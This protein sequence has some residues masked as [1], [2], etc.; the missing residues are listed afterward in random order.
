VPGDGGRGRGGGARLANETRYGLNASVWTGDVER[1]IAARERVESGNVCVNECVISAGRAG[2]AVRRH[3]AERRRHAPRRRRGAAAVLACRRRC[4]SSRGSGRRRDV[5]PLLRKRGRR[6]NR[7][8]ASCSAGERRPARVS[9]AGSVARKR[10]S[11]ARTRP[12]SRDVR[13]VAGA[14]R[15]DG[16]RSERCGSAGRLRDS[17]R[18]RRAVAHAKST[19][20]CSGARRRGPSLARRAKPRHA[21][22]RTGAIVGAVATIR[23]RASRAPPALQD[24]R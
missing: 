15:S 23:A 4:S 8:W 6:S 22:A 10:S 7:S 17:S 24:E 14:K 3:Q 13:G 20:H 2:P 9:T 16:R 12:G 21:S 1:G 19:G 18:T 5:V 11:A